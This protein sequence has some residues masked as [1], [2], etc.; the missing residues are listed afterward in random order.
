MPPNAARRRALSSAISASNPRRTNAAFSV[1]PVSLAALSSKESS[2]FNVVFI[3]I[4]LH[5]MMHAK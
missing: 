1:V 5:E 2:I 3:C 4:T